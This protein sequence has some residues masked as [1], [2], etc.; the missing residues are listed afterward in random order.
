LW[1]FVRHPNF[2]SEQAVWIS[3]YL[4]G[5]AASGKWLNWTLTGP[6][7]LVMLFLGSTALTERISGSKYPGYADYKKDVPKFFPRIFRSIK[8]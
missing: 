5:I 3:F 2:A 8:K 4:F 7:L 1:L 6:F